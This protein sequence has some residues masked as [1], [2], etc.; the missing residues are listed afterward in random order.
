MQAVVNQ[1]HA[2]ENRSL[3][4]PVHGLWGPLAS[5]SNAAKFE[6]RTYCPQQTTIHSHEI[7]D[8]ETHEG[9]QKPYSTVF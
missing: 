6:F 4:I 7:S 2:G 3:D 5:S 1:E 9:T 8:M